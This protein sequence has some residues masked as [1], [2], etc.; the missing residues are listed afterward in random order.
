MT[1]KTTRRRNAVI[2]AVAGVALLTGGW[3]TYALWQQEAKLNGG[4]ITAGQLDI[5]AGT[6]NQWDV[7]AD[8]NDSTIDD[9]T[10]EISAGFD[11]ITLNA[12][13]KG[14][15]QGHPIQKLETWRIVPGDTV[16]LTFPYK[17]TLKGDN[18]VAALTL[19]GMDKLVTGNTFEAGD[20]TIEFQVFGEDGASLGTRTPVTFTDEAAMIGLFEAPHGADESDGEAA[21][22]DAWAPGVVV[23]VL[24]VS[25]DASGTDSMGKS[26]Q[27][28]DT[29]TANLQQVR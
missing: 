29:I 22:A 21:V 17:I 9:V 5:T 25:F 23:V 28:T 24:Y 12:D 3:G 1:T 2:A 26:L 27:L 20:I 8:R 4:T 16:A 15:L 13:G 6:P 7:S 10:T 14:P 18:L 11:A 19:E